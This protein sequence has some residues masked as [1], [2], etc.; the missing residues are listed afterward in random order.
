ML[1]GFSKAKENLFNKGKQQIKAYAC[2]I[3]EMSQVSQPN[4]N[5][6]SV[7]GFRVMKD[8]GIKGLNLLLW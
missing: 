4:Q 6:P 3:Q 5:R 1:K 2:L 7:S 8:A